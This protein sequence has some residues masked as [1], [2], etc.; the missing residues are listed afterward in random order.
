MHTYKQVL[1]IN[2]FRRDRA[3]ET[4]YKWLTRKYKDSDTPLARFICAGSTPLRIAKFGLIQLIYT[5]VLTLAVYPTYNHHALSALLQAGKVLISLWHGSKYTV[6]TVPRRML[7][8]SMSQ[9]DL[10]QMIGLSQEQLV[11]K[12]ALPGRPSLPPTRNGKSSGSE[13]EGE[14]PG[15]GL[16]GGRTP[17]VLPES[18]VRRASR[19][20][21][22]LSG[23]GAR[24]THVHG[25]ESG[26]EDQ[27]PAEVAA[28]SRSGL[29]RVQIGHVQAAPA[30]TLRNRF[31]VGIETY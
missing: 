5:I 6:E 28:G 15:R 4:S 7:Q 26:E 24:R 3:F 31:Q 21:R 2:L 17:R 27:D 19:S 22:N 9:L 8:E 1:F 30:H 16:G 12:P 23:G 18:G 14:L 25:E 29:Q 13:G 10:T 20:A 11:T